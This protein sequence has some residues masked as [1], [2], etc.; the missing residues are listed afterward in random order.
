[1]LSVCSL[2]SPC[3]HFFE[4]STVRLVLSLSRF[5]RLSVSFVSPCFFQTV[6]SRV[7]T[8]YCSS[9]VC[10]RRYRALFTLRNLNTPG[11]ITAIATAL[12][13]DTSSALLRHEIAFVLGQLRPCEALSEVLVE[14]DAKGRRA[15][16]HRESPSSSSS[17]PHSSAGSSTTGAAPSPV[18]QISEL[19]FDSTRG[20]G[21]LELTSDQSVEQ[22]GKDDILRKEAISKILSVHTPD[23]A[24]NVAASALITC[25][26][27]ESEHPMA[28]HEAALALGSLGVS[29]EAGDI[30]WKNEESIRSIVIETL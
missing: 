13:R 3:R 6:N 26:T 27:N 16:E 14:S 22:R 9:R 30:S 12:E 18:S 25:L 10:S 4:V 1:M 7:L 11:S 17:S 8:F 21:A 5:F 19:A 15:D 23:G 28:R 24:A 29:P 20:E 2:S